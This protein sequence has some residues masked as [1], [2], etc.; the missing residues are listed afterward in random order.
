MQQ[1]PSLGTR[2][3]TYRTN[4]TTPPG[5]STGVLLFPVWRPL[6]TGRKPHME[7]WGLAGGWGP[8]QPVGHGLSLVEDALENVQPSPSLAGKS[9]AEA[10]QAAILWDYKAGSDWYSAMAT[11]GICSHWR[12]SQ[13]RGFVSSPRS[14][15]HGTLVRRYLNFYQNVCCFL[16]LAISGQPNSMRRVEIEVDSSTI[17]ICVT[18]IPSLIGSCLSFLLPR[19]LF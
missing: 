18:W 17:A 5:I 10:W 7:T 2:N 4:S 16:L 6:E 11:L 19:T 15:Q 8:P 3:W 9:W 1:L 14:T 13:F 12:I